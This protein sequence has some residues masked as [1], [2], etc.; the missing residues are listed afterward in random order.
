MTRRRIFRFTGKKHSDRPSKVAS[1]VAETEVEIICLIWKYRLDYENPFIRNEK[2][3]F[4][5]V[6]F[7][8]AF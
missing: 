6:A 3:H 8:A 1:S 5:N 2:E 4:L 7:E